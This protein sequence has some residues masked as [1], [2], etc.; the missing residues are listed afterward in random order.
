ME[1]YFYYR[2]ED[3]YSR[4]TCPLLMLPDADVLENERET[5]V[6]HALQTLAPQAEIANVSG[7]NHPYGWL[8][9]PDGAVQA[10]LK[11]L[12]DTAR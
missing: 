4:V 7:W 6:I 1:H 9:D 12:D 10:I 11:F 3:Y 2:F 8:L 5:A